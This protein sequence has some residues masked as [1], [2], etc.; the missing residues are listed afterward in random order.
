MLVGD[1]LQ[2]VYAVLTKKVFKKC[3]HTQENPKGQKETSRQIQ[4]L[5][6]VV[7][8]SIEMP[9]P[10]PELIYEIS[11]NSKGS[12]KERLIALHIHS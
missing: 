9:A 2:E 12:N 3:L 7:T 1:V 11:L 4:L 5:V 6:K 10:M 8:P